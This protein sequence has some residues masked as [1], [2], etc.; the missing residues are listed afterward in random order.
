MSGEIENI[1]K[2]LEDYTE[3][4][5]KG[6]EENAILLGEEAV[7]TLK[8]SGPKNTGKY[9]KGW[10]AKVLKDKGHINVI[11]HNAKYY[12]LTHLLEYG[13]AK[14]NGGRTRGYAHIVP[15]EKLVKEKFITKVEEC[16]KKGGS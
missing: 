6:V 5:T 15:V 2:I 8:A 3:E 12:R 9:R 16:I 11:V 10:R 1:K 4:V 7:K 14:R 13:H